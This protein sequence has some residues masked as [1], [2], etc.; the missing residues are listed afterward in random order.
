MANP[1]RPQ[2]FRPHG[3]VLQQIEMTAGARVFPGDA[4]NLKSDGKVDPAAATED[5]FG[6][7]LSYADADLSPVL[8]SIH[9]E[10]IYVVQ[11]D[12]T[13]VTALTSI[14]NVADIV[15]TAG[16]TTYNQS[17]M[18][19][20]S[21]VAAAGGSQQLVIVGVAGT[22]GNAYGT[23]VDLLVKINEQQLNGE[24]DFAGI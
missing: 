14:G 4:V 20:D 13:E 6:V 23:N 15:A 11:S 19:L 3:E 9:P 12:E 21:S 17:R 5:I 16:N 10:Q 24:N 2:G 18:E 7:A 1:D 8:V 22:V